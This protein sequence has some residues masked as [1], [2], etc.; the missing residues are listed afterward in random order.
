MRVICANIAKAGFAIAGSPPPPGEV[1]PRPRP[2]EEPE[3]LAALG[4]WLPLKP[5]ASHR[6][7]GCRGA[8]SRQPVSSCAFRPCASDLHAFCEPQCSSLERFQFKEKASNPS[9]SLK[10]WEHWA[11]RRLT[12]IFG[13]LQ[14]LVSLLIRM[15]IDSLFYDLS[16]F[17]LALKT[18]LVT[19]P[20]PGST[21]VTFPGSFESRQNSTTSATSRGCLTPGKVV[22]ECA[23]TFVVLTVLR[24]LS[25]V[26]PPFMIRLLLPLDPRPRP[27]FLQPV[28]YC[29]KV[30][31]RPCPRTSTSASAGLRLGWLKRSRQVFH[32]TGKLDFLLLVVLPLLKFC[33]AVD[34]A[35]IGG[36]LGLLRRSSG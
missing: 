23:K 15:S 27:W 25:T 35:P 11:H 31:A 36:Y 3:N 16:F 24:R 28:V 2:K 13:L 33:V 30:V 26:I 7:C 14:S 5:C 4:E 18:T 32:G 22:R 17:F 8:S 1:E 21:T 20:F 6:A 10:P 34:V 29:P 12:R 9:R 19:P